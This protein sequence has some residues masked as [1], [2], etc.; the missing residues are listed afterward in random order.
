MPGL[1][2]GHFVFVLVATT[3]FGLNSHW[4]KWIAK[5]LCEFKRKADGRISKWHE[6]HWSPAERAASA[7]PSAKALKAAGGYKVAAS[8]AGNDSNWRRRSS[9]MKPRHPRVQVGCRLVRGL[10]GWHQKSRSRGRSGGSARQ[11]RRHHARDT[12]IPPHVAG[13][14][15]RGDHHLNLGP[16]VCQ[17]VAPRHQRACD[18]ASSGEAASAQHLLDQRPEGSVRP[19]QHYSAA[20][21]RR[22]RL[23]QSPGAG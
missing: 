20:K 1:R 22:H 19:G 3:M 6:S 12:P 16:S 9:R 11:Q 2:A 17:H 8:Y 10:R 18:R 14:V 15:E 13:T 23:H 7:P 4:T 5:L 21:G